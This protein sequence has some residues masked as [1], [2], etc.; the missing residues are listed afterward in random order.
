MTFNEVFTFNHLYECAKDCCKGVRWK[1]ST[2]IFEMYLVENVSILY[3]QLHK[4]KY[5]SKGFYKFNLPLKRGRSRQISAVHISERC[6]QKCLCRYCLEPLIVP[7]L[8]YDNSACI[9]GKGIDFAIG[10]LRKHFFDN[11]LSTHNLG[12]FLKTD[13]SKYFENI[14]HNI[15]LDKMGRKI[16]DVKLF[17]LYKYFVDNC[18]EKGLSLGSEIS[19]VSAMY[20]VNDLDHYIKEKLKIKQ[21]AR[22]MDDAYL[23]NQ[24]KKTLKQILNEIKHFCDKLNIIFNKKKT[25]IYKINKGCIFLNKHITISDAGKI[26]VWC[27]YETRKRQ[28]RKDRIIKNKYGEDSQNYKTYHSIYL[29]LKR[30]KW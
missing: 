17:E 24:D 11:F 19:H 25:T 6:V 13:F 1:T 9:K 23:I 10:R 20:F 18:G 28:N 12:Y 4:G 27:K 7:S 22:Y 5:K 29:Y 26:N 15:L 16:K 30:K 2:K 8:I 3:D 21:Y 14:D